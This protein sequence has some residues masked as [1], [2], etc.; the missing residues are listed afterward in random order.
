MRAGVELGEEGGEATNHQR[1]AA[2]GEMDHRRIE[3]RPLE[4][5]RENNGGGEARRGL[6]EDDMLALRCDTNGDK[7]TAGATPREL[8]RA[9]PEAY[10]GVPSQPHLHLLDKEMAG[11]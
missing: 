3:V 11:K 2:L 6:V 10:P 7:D 9:R 4:K 1:E 5:S 8:P